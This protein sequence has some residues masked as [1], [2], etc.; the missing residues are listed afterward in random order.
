MSNPHQGHRARVKTEFRDNGLEHF[1]PH[2]ILELLL[3]YSTP[4]KDTNEMGHALID[5]FG[6]LTGVFDAPYELLCE[7][8]GLKE[9]SATL[10][11]LVSSIIRAYMD[12]YTSQNDT[13]VTPEEAKKYMQC[14]FLCE[15]LECI[16]LACLG[17][18]DKVLFCTRIAEG[19]PETVSVTPGEVVR[20]VLRA[21]GVKAILA[22]NHP[23]G[24]CNPSSRD[25]RTTSILFEEL[26]R[27]DIELVDHVIVAP[28]GVYSMRENNMFPRTR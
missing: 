2:K 16:Y 28:D 3:F 17:Y 6:S 5:R 1:P 21:N 13:L 19:S 26:R 24:I 9:H 18:N 14:K 20:T 4:R 7:T 10:I 15:P 23:N 22:H 8:P 11:K 25:L 12:D 27:V